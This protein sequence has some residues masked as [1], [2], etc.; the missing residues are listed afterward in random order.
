MAIGDI[1]DA[2]GNVITP[3]QTGSGGGGDGGEDGGAGQAFQYGMVGAV[4]FGKSVGAA[5]ETAESYLPKALRAPGDA[6]VDQS[7]EGWA[8]RYAENRARIMGN[9]KNLQTEHPYATMAG[10]VAP[11]LAAPELG[12]AGWAGYG[13]AS[14][15]GEGV[16]QG[17]SAGGILAQTALGGA[18]GAIGSEAS[19]LLA[20]AAATTRDAVLAA[21]KRLKS[22]AN[23]EGVT[24]PRYAV[25]TGLTQQFGKIG[26]SIPGMSTPLR[27]E[28]AK[29]IAGLGSAADDAAAGATKE[30]SGAAASAG[31]KNWIGPV[32][33]DDVNNAYNRVTQ[34]LTN[35]DAQTPLSATQSIAN[36]IVANRG[37]LQD[38]SGALQ[39]VQKALDVG[40]GT[41]SEI[42]ALRSSI[43]EQLAPGSI[44]PAGVQGSELKQLYDGLSSDLERAAYTAG[45]QPAV[46]AH[47]AATATAKNIAAQRA[48]LTELLGG[49]KGDASNE[50]VF[51][52][53]QR[54]AGSTN[55][56]DIDLLRQA[57]SV[58]PPQSWDS[59]SRGMV[60]TLG[61]DADGNFS[62]S[63]FIT[64]YGKISD[65]AKDELFAQNTPLRQNL[66]DLHTVSQQWKHLEQY[67]NPSGTGGHAV[68]AAAI[69]HGWHAPLETL[70]MFLGAQQFGKLLATPAGAGAFGAFS[71][72]V[73]SRNIRAIQQAS[74]R[75]TATAGAQL[76][77]RADPMA[78]ASL[79]L[80]HFMPE[81]VEGGGADQSGN[82]PQ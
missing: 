35:P 17:D 47:L 30:S 72:A 77:A 13:A 10:S 49:K 32:S 80:H 55:S 22:T 12:T 39:Q 4:P 43:G 33:T 15:L 6:P 31:L 2:Q 27:E 16:E 62:T 54:A 20:P 7:G 19:K 11:L 59:V 51:G 8:Q 9:A 75:V 64:D 60:S 42:K 18:G 46:D 78:L 41:Y 52:A 36:R 26:F 82:T 63:R 74:A 23:P 73:G 53:L 5:V 45:G 66:D 71:R 25:G 68:G 34:A 70:G 65:A 57:R 44:L 76:G 21:A 61:R 58:V 38:P 29:S 56:A 48:Q 50:A 24:L 14:G 40:Q 67:A 69:L 79:A 28:T 3:A 81:A 37:K 1:V